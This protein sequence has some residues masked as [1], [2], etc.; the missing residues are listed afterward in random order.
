MSSE[1]V[2]VGALIDDF[3]RYKRSLGF[4]YRSHTSQLKS[5]ARFL[6]SRQAPGRPVVTEEDV[7]EWCA[8][9][10]GEQCTSRSLR[11][12]LA[13]QFALYL[14]RM[15]RED[16]YVLPKGV[17]PKTQ[18]DFVPYIFTLQ[19]ISDVTDAFDAMKPN[20][21]SPNCH[22]IYPA[23]FRTIYGCALR[24]GEAMRLKLSEVDLES[25][26]LAIN[27]S[28]NDRSRIVP[29]SPSLRD[30]L[31]GYWDEMG[32]AGEDPDGPLFPARRGGPRPD[33]G[34]PEY[35]V[36][37]KRFEEAGVR[38][39][40]GKVP[41]VHDL[42]HSAACHALMRAEEEGVSMFSFLPTLSRYLGHQHIGDT[43]KYL[44][45]FAPLQDAAMAKMDAYDDIYP[46]TGGDGHG[47]RM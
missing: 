1:I 37:K 22:L 40:Y 4:A 8:P 38:N 14:R 46:E 2:D 27:H 43:E 6:Q 9:R 25:G 20:S 11:G 7:V 16:C 21:K 31:A 19:E 5:L 3:V 47:E 17:V 42:R 41:R 12:V 45:L 35:H 32:F 13:R 30:Y 10:E 18:S 26:V 23:M 29:M 44:H 33:H 28:K 24:R 39:Q 36:F 34:W 15:G